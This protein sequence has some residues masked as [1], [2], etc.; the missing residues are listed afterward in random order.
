M[1]LRSCDSVALNV[2]V[3]MLACVN[4]IPSVLVSVCVIGFEKRGNSVH[5][6]N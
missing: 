2:H 5:A 1:V 6:R 3:L 4:L